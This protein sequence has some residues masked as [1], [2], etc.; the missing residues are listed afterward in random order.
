MNKA[1]FITIFFFLTSVFFCQGKEELRF[2]MKYGFIKGGEARFE[3]SDTVFNGKP[4]IHY[5]LRVKTT[6]ITDKLF[7]VND[8]YES[9]VDKTTLLPYK[10]IRNI[11]E[12]KYRYYNEVLYFHDSDSIYS[13]RSGGK[14]VQPELLDILSVFFYFTSPKFMTN[15]RVGDVVTMPALHADKIN[16]VS[17]GYYKDEQIQTKHGKLDCYALAPVVDKGKLLERSDGLKFYVSKENKIPVL[18]EFDM[19]IGA[20]KAILKSYK[21]DGKELLK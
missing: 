10:S 3:I 5:Y 13:Q 9:I 6:G 4:A 2:N 16:D 11:A 12:G 18:L 1:V 21:V 7:E 14:K 8:I 17:I 19:K 20:L 15:I